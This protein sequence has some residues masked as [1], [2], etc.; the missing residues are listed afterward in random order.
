L[1]DEPLDDDVVDRAAPTLAE[2]PGSGPIPRSV[3]GR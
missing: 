3:P 2:D 1:D